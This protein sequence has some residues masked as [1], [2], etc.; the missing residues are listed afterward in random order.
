MLSAVST[1][2]TDGFYFDG[3]VRM[4]AVALIQ[5][6]G[7]DAPERV[8]EHVAQ[9]RREGHEEAARFWEAI[10]EKISFLLEEADNSGTE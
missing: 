5:M 8:A 6:F 4:A 9:V 1:K 2:P 3:D 10:A 7:D